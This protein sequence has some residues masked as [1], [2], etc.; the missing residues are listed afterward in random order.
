MTADEV[1]EVFEATFPP[2]RLCG[3]KR[4]AV[5]CAGVPSQPCHAPFQGGLCCQRLARSCALV[6]RGK[7]R[8]QLADFGYWYEPERSG[9][10]Q[11]RFE[12]RRGAAAGT[13]VDFLG[14][15][16]APVSCQ[17]LQLRSARR[18]VGC[19]SVPCPSDGP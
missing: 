7:R 15:G 4:R 11:S 2:V 6:H 3:G 13:G 16:G 9:E 10:T 12:A 14:G 1:I 17:L 8:R 5:L 18:S 19:I